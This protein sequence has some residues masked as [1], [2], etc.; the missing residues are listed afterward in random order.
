MS[1]IN[2]LLSGRLPVQLPPGTQLAVN[3]FLPCVYLFCFL[4]AN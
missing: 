1:A 2:G 4:I 3:C